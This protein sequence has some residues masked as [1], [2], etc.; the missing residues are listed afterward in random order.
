[1]FESSFGFVLAL[2]PFIPVNYPPKLKASAESVG[3]PWWRPHWFQFSPI[4]A[5]VFGVAS[6]SREVPF[7][8]AY[9]TLAPES[10]TIQG[11][12]R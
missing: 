7:L 12:D 9:L 6:G 4:V 1:M 3:I 5:G 11:L 8:G 2:D 10:S